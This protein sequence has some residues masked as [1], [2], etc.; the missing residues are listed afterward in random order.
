MSQSFDLLLRDCANVCGWFRARG[1]EVD[2]HDVYADL[3]AHAL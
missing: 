3:M 1:L 2:E